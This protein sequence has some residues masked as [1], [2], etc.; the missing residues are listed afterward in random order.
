MSVRRALAW[1]FLGQTC[2][3]SVQF[4]GSVIVARLLSPY[5]I[6]IFAVAMATVG[7]ISTI[8]S[9]GLHNFIVR[10]AEVNEELLATA[11]TL[12]TILNVV[13]AAAIFGGS[14][15]VAML[16]HE[17][18][19]GR[20][21]AVIA[22]SSLFSIF[23]FRP[24]AMLQRNMQF[25]PL[26]IIQALRAILT[27][28]IVIL[29]AY[30]GFSYMS[31]AWGVLI[32]GA[33]SS[34]AAM[35]VG[36]SHVR[37]AWRL[38]GWRVLTGFGLRMAA[39]GGLGV[40]ANRLSEII[41]ARLL[42]LV[43]LGLYTRAASIISLFWDNVYG[44]ITNVLFSR[45]AEEYRSRGSL[46]VAYLRSL[47]ILTAVMWP[48]FGGLSVLAGPLIFH[49][50]GP[51]WIEAASPLAVLAIAHLLLIS[52]TMTWE[53]FVIRDETSRQARFEFI[54]SGFG[55]LVFVIG[56]VFNITAAAGAR[57]VEALFALGLYTPHLTRM[58]STTIGEFLVIYLRSALV[59]LAAIFPSL[60]LMIYHDWA[61]EV[62]ILQ[63]VIA[64]VLGIVCWLA[65]LAAMRHDVMDEIRRLLARVPRPTVKHSAP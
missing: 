56:S 20:V 46:R 48:A 63:M 23:D 27:T 8:Q 41:L 42:G 35:I 54:K 11:F 7:L 58:T 25:R 15:I 65:L 44:V 14:F 59:T 62:P 53:I 1:S 61:Y 36:R 2:L 4:I 6:G 19:V 3:F 31:P 33:F 60:A 28:S 22:I 34:T 52:M 32:G 30:Q 45:L 49:L 17:E 13:V 55:F 38:E 9:F 43:A 57:I 5:E 39:I 21:M 47:S 64:V 12:N 29:L 24:R 18:A 51:K 10:E 26:A 16:L 37:F 40:L 50:Y